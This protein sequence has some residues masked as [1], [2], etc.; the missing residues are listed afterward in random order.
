MTAGWILVFMPAL[1]ELTISILL[2]A[3]GTETIGVVVFNLQD[4][5]YREVAAAL[6]CIV[7]AILIFGNILLKKLTGGV[8]GF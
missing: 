7:I 4:A 2:Y 6:A 3:H 8:S 5:G 1:R